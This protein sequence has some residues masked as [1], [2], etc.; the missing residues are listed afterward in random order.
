M[1]LPRLL[2]ATLNLMHTDSRTNGV[3]LDRQSVVE[4]FPAEGQGPGELLGTHG[5]IRRNSL[6]L[7]GARLVPVAQ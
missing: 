3:D 4:L 7:P 5:A 2:R 6:S 1:P